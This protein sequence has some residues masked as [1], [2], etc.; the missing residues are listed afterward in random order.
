[1]SKRNYA[2]EYQKSIENKVNISFRIDKEIYIKF[3][4]KLE[5]EGKSINKT[6]K[7]F[8]TNY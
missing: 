4:E 8:I 1:M 3:K 2:R 7:E 6:L 5:K